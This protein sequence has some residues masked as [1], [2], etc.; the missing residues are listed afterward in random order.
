MTDLFRDTSSNARSFSPFSLFKALVHRWGSPGSDKARRET[1]PAPVSGMQGRFSTAAQA[2][3]FEVS[4][5]KV[6]PF[7]ETNTMPG[8]WDLSELIKS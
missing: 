3:S 8:G 6:N 4:P 7:P 2:A 1:R 5:A